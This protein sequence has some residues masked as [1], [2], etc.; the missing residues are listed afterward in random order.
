[1][2]VA[3]NG[4]LTDHLDAPG[5]AQISRQTWGNNTTRATAQTGDNEWFTP[6]EILDAAREV[7]GRFDL[8][9]A[10]DDV[11]QDQVRAARYFTAE[12]NG[13]EREWHG[14][15]WLNP[16]YAQPLIA[17]FISK[18]IAERNAGRTTAAIMLTNN[19]ADT[20]W[21]HEAASA[22]AVVCFTRGRIQFYKPAGGPSTPLQG[23]AFFYFGDHVEAFTARF[24]KIGSVLELIR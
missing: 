21:W 24:Q 17:Q 16:P 8:D 23:Q 20:A 10:S 12:D 14:R 7:L 6:T 5:A 11:A 2:V 4:P 1:M 3:A 15:V 22:S 13:L 19:S 9:P 18:L